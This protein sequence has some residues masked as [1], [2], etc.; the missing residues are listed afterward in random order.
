[1]GKYK[2]E[3]IKNVKRANETFIGTSIDEDKNKIYEC[4]RNLANHI[5]E[6]KSSLFNIA[7]G[8]TEASSEKRNAIVWIDIKCPAMISDDEV[9]RCIAAMIEDTDDFT[10]AVLSNGKTR[11]SF[12]VRDIWR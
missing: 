10:V 1:M 9:K 12:G 3:Y 4:I 2:D 11:M 8:Y 6:K 5:S 7:Y